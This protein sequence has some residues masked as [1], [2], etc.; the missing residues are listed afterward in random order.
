MKQKLLRLVA[1]TP[2]VRMAVAVMV[3]TME[4]VRA[5][6]VRIDVVVIQTTAAQNR[7]SFKNPTMLD[8]SSHCTLQSIVNLIINLNICS[9]KI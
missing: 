3:V 8:Y 7:K 5:A 1:N 4:S 6:V 9:G 2:V